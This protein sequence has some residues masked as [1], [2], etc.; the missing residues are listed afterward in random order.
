MFCGEGHKQPTLSMQFHPNGKWLITGGLDTAVCLWAVPDLDMLD[1]EDEVTEHAKPIV[2][3]YPH[4]FSTEVHHNY[5]DSIHFYGNLILSKA[6]KDPSAGSSNEILLW[7]I[8]G[9]D[10]NSPAP[11][12]PP[13]PSPGQY[14]RS[15]FPHTASSRGFQRLLSFSIPYTDRFYHRF[16]LLHQPNMR[17]ILCL[18][19]QSSTF[20]FWDLQRLEEGTEP[21]EEKPRARSKG[22]RK[23]K[24]KES[25]ESLNRLDGLRA[26]SQSVISESTGGAT[27][28]PSSTSVSTPERKYSLSDPFTP[29]KA[30]ATV[31][32]KT[33]LCRNGKGQDQ[34]F[35]TSQMSWS[36]DGTWLVACGDK[37]MVCIFHRDR[38]R[39]NGVTKGLDAAVGGAESKP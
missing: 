3:Y 33:S 24:Q 1:T 21:I 18:G 27:P 13:V 28:M 20:L 37:G 34:H 12:T 17:P 6:A 8:D 10:A 22:G 39:V 29:L 2:V 7:K 30:H 11:D 19:N 26:E 38:S 4:F 5:V 25:T 36:P 14:T 9:F 31:M 35:A 16:G 32:P 23:A 15:S